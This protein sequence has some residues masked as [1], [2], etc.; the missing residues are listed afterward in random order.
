MVD[1]LKWALPCPPRPPRATTTWSP[2]SFQV[3]EQMARGRDREPGSPAGT[4]MTR[5]VAAAPEAIGALAVLA[6]FGL[7]VAL[8]GEVGQVRIAFANHE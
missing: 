1:D 8:V 2:G 4:S 5:S 6:A 7:P 3:A